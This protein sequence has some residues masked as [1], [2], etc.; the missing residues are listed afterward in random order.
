TIQGQG[1]AKPVISGNNTSRVFEVRATVTLTNLALV[2][3]NGTAGRHFI[4]INIPA[5]LASAFTAVPPDGEGGAIYN[6]GS[7]T[8]QGCT[9]S[10]NSA[11][12]SDSGTFV[13]AAGGAL[14]NAGGATAL[15]RSSTLSGNSAA[16]SLWGG[17]AQT[18]VAK[19][20]A[21]YNDVG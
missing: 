6:A 8:L 3:G 4:P 9:L 20:G 13:I 2:N 17:A 15:V 11:V 7:L 12:V 18:V 19:G 14:Y 21:I 5:D 1:S 16:V 10:G